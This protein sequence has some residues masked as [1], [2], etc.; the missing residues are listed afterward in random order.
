MTND[1]QKQQAKEKAKKKCIKI[2]NICSYICTALLILLLLLTGLQ[3]CGGK[4][5]SG[6]S[7]ESPIQV[8]N[9]A[10][11][12]WHFKDV[13]DAESLDHFDQSEWQILFETQAGTR[14]QYIYIDDYTISYRYDR[15]SEPYY[16]YTQQYGWDGVSGQNLT[17][18][19]EFS[20]L[21]YDNED[22]I[23][24]LTINASLVAPLTT[25]TFNE[26]FNYN[27]PLGLNVGIT[28]L[29]YL[30][31]LAW[32]NV[33]DV[34]N[35]TK[36]ETTATL[37]LLPFYANGRLYNAINTHYLIARSN[38]ALFTMDDKDVVAQ[39]KESLCV[40]DYMAFA[41]IQGSSV[42][43]SD[44][45][46]IRDT[47]QVEY[48][49]DTQTAY[50]TSTTWVN[51]GFRCL[52]FSGYVITGDL[53][54]RLIAFNNNNDLI[55]YTD[56]NELTNTFTLFAGVFTALVP[57]LSIKILPYVSIGLLVFIPLVFAVIIFII[58]KIK[59]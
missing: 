45:V 26:A 16:A 21:N 41:Y 34:L 19:G 28:G 39:V 23:D 58:D 6:V 42:S 17:F 24:F 31:D 14:Y 9:L 53:S 13:L 36:T 8:E 4:S 43:Y 48:T 33:N 2:L 51:D 12:Q 15:D 7:A 3:S 29:P 10:R 55:I 27:A 47:T 49:G 38:N 52:N 32:V 50:K 56:D 35:T 30:N 1:I 37:L 22:L 46:N 18:Y 57:I 11:T 44:I 59:K 25:F 5:A 20:Y 40:Y 54:S